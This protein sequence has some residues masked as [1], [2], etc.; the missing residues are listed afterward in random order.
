[1]RPSTGFGGLFRKAG[2]DRRTVGEKKRGKGRSFFVGRPFTDRWEVGEVVF[3]VPGHQADHPVPRC[4]VPGAFEDRVGSL[5]AGGIKPRARARFL[6]PVDRLIKGKCI[7]ENLRARSASSSEPKG[8]FA[9]P[10]DQRASGEPDSK[11]RLMIKR[12]YLL[13]YFFPPFSLFKSHM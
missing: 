5:T 9:R 4:A 7:S 12:S 3:L 11:P 2:G 6:S 8:R 10:R 1:M 13:L